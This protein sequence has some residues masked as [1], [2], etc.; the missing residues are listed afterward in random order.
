[1][2]K[3]IPTA[4]QLR[5]LKDLHVQLHYLQDKLGFHE[6][7]THIFFDGDGIEETI[8]VEADGVGGATLYRFDD[9]ESGPNTRQELASMWFESE[10]E[11]MMFAQRML[12]DMGT[13]WINDIEERLI[14]RAPRVHEPSFYTPDGRGFMVFYG[15]SEYAARLAF[16]QWLATAASTALVGIS[17]A[18]QDTPERQ[19]VYAI[20]R[21]PDNDRL[22][23]REL[24]S[25]AMY[26]PATHGAFIDL[27]LEKFVLGGRDYRRVERTYV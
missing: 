15:I 24:V 5:E 16:G 7:G 2:S 10:A 27:V 22:R 6:R 18:V 26:Q 8:I 23:L 21:S 3:P 19:E 9:Y 14:V 4:K 17:F 11:A 1:M 13:K 12:D 25:G 20:E